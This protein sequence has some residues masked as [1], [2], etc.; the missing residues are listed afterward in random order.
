MGLKA[1]QTDLANNYNRLSSSI[2]LKANTSD[3]YSTSNTYT[4]T[5]VNQQIANLVDSAPTTLNT[6]NEL[7]LALGN[8]KNFSTTITSSRNKA[9]H[10]NKL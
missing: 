9:T 10:I 4:K 3:V 2:N 7:A 5:E 6:L 1:N 8:D